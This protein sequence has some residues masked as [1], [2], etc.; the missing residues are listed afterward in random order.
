MRN[1]LG[2]ITVLFVASF[3]F[4]A[5]TELPQQ[6]DCALQAAAV[7]VQADFAPAQAPAVFESLGQDV[8]LTVLPS[9][10]S[11][12]GTSCSIPGTLKRCQWQPGEPELCVCQSNHTW[13]CG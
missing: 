2:V 10:F 9:C 7:E 8:V 6:G 3:G 5:Q 11:V 12:E 4:L 13:H 1:A